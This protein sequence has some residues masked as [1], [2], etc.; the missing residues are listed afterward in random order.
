[1]G[2]VVQ[3]FVLLL[4]LEALYRMF[5]LPRD[6][7]EESLYGLVVAVDFGALYG[8]PAE[9][10][11]GEEE[12]CGGEKE[13]PEVS[14]DGDQTG[15]Y[16]DDEDGG[17]RESDSEDDVELVLEKLFRDLHGFLGLAERAR[18]REERS[19]REGEVCWSLILTKEGK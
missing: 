11:H 13:G 18:E 8:S 12:E 19:E 15:C 1:M 3:R 7:I 10:D 5:K 16:E 4:G 6:V 14:Q 9:E 2:F 17:E